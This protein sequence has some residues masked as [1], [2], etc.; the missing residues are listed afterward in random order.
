MLCDGCVVQFG[1]V[2]KSNWK[3]SMS[4][5]G[6]VCTVSSCGTL[7]DSHVPDVCCHRNSVDFECSFGLSVLRDSPS[8]WVR[9]KDLRQSPL[10]T[11]DCFDLKE[12]LIAS[13]DLKD[14]SLL[15]K[16]ACQLAKAGLR[17]CWN[18]IFRGT[19]KNMFCPSSPEPRSTEFSH[20]V[21]FIQ[22]SRQVTVVSSVVSICC[23]LSLHICNQLVY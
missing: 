6:H 5:V 19:K 18:M 3:S 7:T 4:S 11:N 12:W 8:Q 9:S 22:L 13:I 16:H 23:S 21:S 17:R 20:S 1:S 14:I 15:L 10:L 2:S